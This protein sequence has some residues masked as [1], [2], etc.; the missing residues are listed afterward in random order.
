M[1]G[2]SPRADAMVDMLGKVLKAGR[3]GAEK[4]ARMG[5]ERLLLRQ[6]RTDRD[7]LYRKLG[8]ETRELLETGDL[9]H[10]GLRR[11]VGRIA[12]I[13]GRIVDVE[14]AIRRGGEA[15]EPDPAEAPEGSAG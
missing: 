14:E 15:V 8:K 2:N 9:E 5:R 12:E 13:E 7:R 4:V 10:P 11:A 6:L 3:Q 1:A